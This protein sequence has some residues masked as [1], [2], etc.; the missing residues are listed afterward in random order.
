MDSPSSAQRATEGK[1]THGYPVHLLCVLRLESCVQLPLFPVFMP[2]SFEFG[3]IA[4]THP[5]VL[6]C[7]LDELVVGDVFQGFLQ[8]EDSWRGYFQRFVG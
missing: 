8:A 7:D 2:L 1:Q 3:E 4:F 6:W 5:D